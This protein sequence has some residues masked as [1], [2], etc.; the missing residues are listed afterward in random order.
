MQFLVFSNARIGIYS[1][2]CNILSLRNPSTLSC[3]L[4]IEHLRLGE[5]GSKYGSM[6]TVQPH[7]QYSPCHCRSRYDRS[8]VAGMLNVSDIY[9]MAFSPDGTLLLIVDVLGGGIL[10]NFTKRILLA[11]LRFKEK[12]HGIKFSPDGH[13][14]AV[15]CANYVD[16]PTFF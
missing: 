3:G 16:V 8:K 11:T 9:N 12:T 7:I 2:Q 6:L 4:S 5:V 13:Y 10:I 1:R 14:F 15:T